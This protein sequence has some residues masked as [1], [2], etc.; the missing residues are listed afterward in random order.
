LTAG[1]QK[2]LAHRPAPDNVGFPRDQID[3]MT[4]LLEH[5]SRGCKAKFLDSLGP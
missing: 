5:Q 2:C 4:A 3:R 1:S